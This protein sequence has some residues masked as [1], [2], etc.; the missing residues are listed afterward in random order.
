VDSTSW[1]GVVVL[2]GTV[3]VL[4]LVNGIPSTAAK[5]IDVSPRSWTSLTSW[6]LH[7]VP[8]PPIA[9]ATVDGSWISID[10]RPDSLA[11]LGITVAA[12]KALLQPNQAIP[13]L[14][15][16][17]AIQDEGP[18][19]DWLYKRQFPDS[20]FT[21]ANTNTRALVNGSDFWKVQYP[22]DRKNGGTL[23]C[24]QQRVEEFIPY[25]DA[26]EGAILPVPELYPN[27]HASIYR[28]HVDSL[29]RIR[30]E[31]FAGPPNNLLESLVDVIHLSASADSKAMD[32]DLSRNNI[33]SLTWKCTF[34]FNY[35]QLGN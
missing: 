35:S 15:H 2:S 14:D 28:R 4:A 11:E 23:W 22:K 34:R 31:S 8:S 29:G 32:K 17:V 10:Q 26:H 16:T 25:V 18:N 24:G 7:E 13:E 20:T 3:Q 6:K 1:S 33:T 21:T 9:G 19:H 30:Y 5:R 12:Y 27:S